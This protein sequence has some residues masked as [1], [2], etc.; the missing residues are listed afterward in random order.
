MRIYVNGKAFEETEY[1]GKKILLDTMI[2]CYAHDALS[3]YREK[4]KLV[5]LAGLRGLYVLY[6]SIQNILEFYSVV[7]SRRV[8]KPLSPAKASKIAT[9]YLS[10]KRI[11]KLYPRNLREALKYAVENNVKN[12]DIFDV[13]LAYT[14]KD[15]IDYLWT[16]NVSDFENFKFLKVENPLEFEI[17]WR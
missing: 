12:G 1:Y 16:Q 10:S 3:P 17:K 13:V 6:V 14:A 15:E 7:T 9:T 4:A 11:R 5:I 8:K 2:L